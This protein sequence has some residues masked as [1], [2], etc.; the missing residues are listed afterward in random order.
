MS[1]M[2]TCRPCAVFLCIVVSNNTVMAKAPTPQVF[3]SAPTATVTV[4]N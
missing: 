4:I 3:K 2:C 1:L